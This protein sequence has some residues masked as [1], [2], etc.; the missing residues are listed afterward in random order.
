M[1]SRSAAA[2]VQPGSVPDITMTSA[3]ALALPLLLTATVRVDDH[4][5]KG[6]GASL[7]TAAIQAAIDACGA[8]GG[9]QVT[10]GPRRYLTGSLELRDGVT[11]KLDARAVIL[12]SENVADY[13]NGG[14][15]RGN[16]VKR[17][18]IEGGTIDGRGDIW[19]EKYR[20]YDG[21]AWKSTAQHE[22][23]PKK[24]P[25]FL[26]FSGCSDVTIR[27]VKLIGSPS[28]TLHLYRSTDCL[29]ERVTIRNPLY[30][31]NTD[32]IDINSCRRVTVR[33][34]DIITGDDGIVLKSTDPGHDHPSEDITVERC[35]IWS[36]CNCLKIGTETH[37]SF[38]RIRFA[39]CHL[40]GG[41]DVALERPLSGLAIESVDGAELSDIVAE[42]LTMDNVRA[43]LFIRLGHRGGNS[44]RTQQVEPRVPGRIRNVTIR[45]VKATRSLFE[46]SITGMVG[47]PVEGVTLTNLDLG[48]VGGEDQALAMVT[49]PDAEVVKRYPEAQMFGRLSAYGL[50]C[51]HVDGLQL[52]GVKL[53]YDQPDG[54]PAMVCDDVA[55]LTIN[56]LQPQP[57]RSR[58]PALW[59]LNVRQARLTGC[60]ALEGTKA[61]LV[62]EGDPPS[63]AGISLGRND[64]ATARDPLLHVARGGLVRQGLPLIAETKPGLV[65]LRPDALLL[66]PPMVTVDEP[67]AAPGKAIEVPLGQGRDDGTAQA[68]FSIT[69]GGEYRVW[70]KVYAPSGVSNSYYVAIDDGDAAL[71]DVAALGKWAWERATDR[72]QHDY[73]VTLQPG[74][75]AVQIRNRE[76]A[77]RIAGLVIAAAGAGFDPAAVWK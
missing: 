32:G 12:G 45:N 39:D 23:R 19:F 27:D 48:Y 67:E 69:Q 10:F 13:T 74:E 34:S 66:T 71:V 26:R 9:G 43:P 5:A 60:T 40:Y 15:L 65:L 35:R 44:E 54:R 29:V 51:R 63:E 47:H 14:L 76:S 3:L 8:A 33:D 75:H 11:L 61:F 28:W 55:N 64:L 56:R 24:R 46:S 21:P 49:V 57:P 4:G 50:Y 72:E 38:T 42:N 18:G 36:A 1:R 70:A 30:G 6:D 20:T 59:F 37:D 17:V 16:G 22:Y 53:H 7:D 73:K 41:S 77:T 2:V 31:N 58:W 62:V 68:R 52:D 25:S